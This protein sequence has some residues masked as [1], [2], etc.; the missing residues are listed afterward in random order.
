MPA[1]PH[2]WKNRLSLA[3]NIVAYLETMSKHKQAPK[4]SAR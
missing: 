2:E 1:L 4:E 3:E